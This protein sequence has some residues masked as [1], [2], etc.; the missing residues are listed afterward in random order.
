M[1]KRKCDACGKEKDLSGGATCEKGH[2]I[3]Y[4]C[5]MVTGAFG[6]SRDCRSKCP[7]CDKPLK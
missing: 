4:D 5:K 6:L 1:A 7:I 3:C 2:F